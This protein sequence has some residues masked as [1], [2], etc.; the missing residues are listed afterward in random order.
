[1]LPNQ[2]HSSWKEKEVYLSWNV[3]VWGHKGCDHHISRCVC[4][5]VVFRLNC[6]SSFHVHEK[7]PNFKHTR[8][9][10]HACMR[11]RTHTHT[12]AHTEIRSRSHGWLVFHP[13][14]SDR[15]SVE[16]RLHSIGIPSTQYPCETCSWC[17]A[18]LTLSSSSRHAPL[19]DLSDSAWELGSS[20]GVEMQF[21][22]SSCA[23][24]HWP[25]WC[26]VFLR[27]KK[28]HYVPI[29]QMLEGSWEEKNCLVVLMLC[30]FDV[31]HT[32][33]RNNNKNDATNLDRKQTVVILCGLDAY[34]L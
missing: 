5:C 24:G 28:S 32:K 3:Y 15:R 16:L 25:V 27:A 29:P 13:F 34:Y 8:V 12:H 33:K 7:T 6:A 22:N 2:H 17:L 31:C 21:S 23:A 1:M 4:A 19:S 18:S 10:S 30:G 11:A 14:V 9:H 26:S 20:C